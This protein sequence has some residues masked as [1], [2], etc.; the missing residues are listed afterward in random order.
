MLLVGAAG[1]G[2]TRT[3]FEVATQA[4]ND[5]WAVM[6][7]TAGEA[8]VRSDDLYEAIVAE[9]ADR[10]LIVLDYLNAYGLDLTTLRYR[11]LPDAERYGTKV[12][13]IA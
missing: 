1:V 3:C 9:S 5:G 8:A 4:V 11:V 13:F 10:I 6:H 2:K 7:V 12:A